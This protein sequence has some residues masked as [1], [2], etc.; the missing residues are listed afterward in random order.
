MRVEVE[1]G[2]MESWLELSAREMAGAALICTVIVVWAV[3]PP[4]VAVTTTGTE[5]AAAVL[6]AAMVRAEVADPVAPAGVTETGLKV[7]VMPAGSVPTEKVTGV[8][9]ELA[10]AMERRSVA[11]LPWVM[12]SAE[13]AALAV[14]LGGRVRVAG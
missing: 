8:V 7:A 5:P 11:D 14:R 4:P 6:V 1:V 12:V 2:F 9:K 13:V 3:M 10:V